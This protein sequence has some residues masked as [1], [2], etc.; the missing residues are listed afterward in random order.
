MQTPKNLVNIQ[1]N[2]KS[3]YSIISTNTA[4]YDK[5]RSKAIIMIDF[6]GFNAGFNVIKQVLQFRSMYK[7]VTFIKGN[8]L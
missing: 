2:S 8:I 7:S 4:D 5:C 3:M 6:A 1:H